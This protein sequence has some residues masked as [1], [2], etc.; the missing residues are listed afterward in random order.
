MTRLLQM[1]LSGGLTI[2]AVALFRLLFQNRM[3]RRAMMILWGLVLFQLLVPFRIP[4]PTSIYNISP[5]ME[6][7]VMELLPRMEESAPVSSGMNTYQLI[8]LVWAVGAVA[9][10]GWFLGNHLLARRRYA[11]SVPV[12]QPWKIGRA[13]VRM[14]DGL[15]SPLTYGIFRPVILLPPVL[16]YEGGERL[17]HVLVHES[18]HVRHWDT[19]KKL[20]VL[21]AACV[22]WFNP[23]AWLM[24]Y[25][26]SQ[27]MEMDCDAAAIRI[28]GS[29]EK[30]AYAKTL[31]SMEE[32]KLHSVLQIGF[33]FSSTAGRLK[34]IVRSRVHPV[35]GR[36][37]AALLT[38]V[39]VLCFLTCEM[40]ISAAVTRYFPEPRGAYSD[41]KRPEGFMGFFPAAVEEE[42]VPE[43]S[44]ETQPTEEEMEPIQ[45][46]TEPSKPQ[47][48]PSETTPAP[49][50]PKPTEPKPTVPPETKPA[51][52]HP[53]TV[54]APLHW[55]ASVYETNSF[56]VDTEGVLSAYSGNSAVAAVNL[57]GHSIWV[58]AVGVGTTSIYFTVDGGAPH[59]LLTVTVTE[60][61][62]DL[63][64]NSGDS[65]D[66][67]FVLP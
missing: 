65:G 23:L 6:T 61:W 54:V 62:V 10:F 22:H 17:R 16:V 20:V 30:L 42:T 26:T 29:E 28:L 63:D 44:P 39:L 15:A 57:Q 43:S 60:A 7:P 14:L 25:L 12:S 41:T 64:E 46:Q 5:S 37:L 67:G 35:A 45:P 27:D 24:V 19:A 50:E 51:Q 11:F 8:V 1:T 13:R 31:I 53:Y 49:T 36:I 18:T 38:A 2:L 58:Q 52:E 4:A 33:S 55:E 34:A 9:S 40:R 32:S 59:V 66:T 3:N 56:G 47:T 21:F 48:A